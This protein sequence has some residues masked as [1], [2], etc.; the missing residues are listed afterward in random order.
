MKLVSYFELFMFY[1]IIPLNSAL[2]LKRY[3]K[4]MIAKTGNTFV[5]QPS[6]Y[7][8][9]EMRYTLIIDIKFYFKLCIFGLKTT[10]QFYIVYQIL[11]IYSVSQN[12]VVIYIHDELIWIIFNE[13]SQDLQTFI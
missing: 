5:T 9:L 7:S 8:G 12:K 10:Y 2:S 3:L 1:E 4:L 13:T 11:C 6:S